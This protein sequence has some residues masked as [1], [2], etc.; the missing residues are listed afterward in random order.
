MNLTKASSILS[1]KIAICYPTIRTPNLSIKKVP[2][3][4]NKNMDRKEFLKPHI[5]KKNPYHILSTKIKFGNFAGS[6]HFASTVPK[7]FA[8][9]YYLRN[10]PRKDWGEEPLFGDFDKS[11]MK[12][13]Q[14]L[15]T[16]I[17]PI[18]TGSIKGL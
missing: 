12:R 14:L 18:A 4:I 15:N 17:I 6:C 1:S 16:K 9:G 11:S 5:N 2:K 3:L 7:V 8:N 13:T 10:M